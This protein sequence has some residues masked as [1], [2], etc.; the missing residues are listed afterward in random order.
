MP[1]FFRL[2]F[3]ST[4]WLLAGLL[5]FLIALQSWITYRNYQSE[6]KLLV[7]NVNESM[8]SS[9]EAFR[10]YDDNAE[11]MRSILTYSERATALQ[12]EAN[13]ITNLIANP[14]FELG[15][16]LFSS[17]Y[18]AYSYSPGARLA[19]NIG[20]YTIVDSAGTA[21][22][23][24]RG[25]GFG[26]G[27]KFLANDGAIASGRKVWSQK[28]KCKSNASYHL[29]FHVTSLSLAHDVDTANEYWDR[30][31]LKI[32]INDAVV[33]YVFAPA[34]MM[35]W[36]MFQRNWISGND[37]VADISIIDVNTGGRYNDFG[38]DHLV[39]GLANEISNNVAA[40]PILYNAPTS[41]PEGN[42]AEDLG[43]L[44][45]L[46]REEF[47][48]RSVNINFRVD[49]IPS[50]RFEEMEYDVQ[51]L[52]NR[53]S[54]KFYERHYVLNGDLFSTYY[55]LDSETL[56]KCC[57]LNYNAYLLEKIFGQLLLLGLS[58]FLSGL[59]LFF[60][61]RFLQKQEQVTRLKYDITS[62]ITHELKT[63]IATILAATESLQKFVAT[64]DKE[65]TERYL[66]ITRIQANRLNQLVEKALSYSEIEEDGFALSLRKIDINDLIKELAE[67]E[68]F[69]AK[70]HVSVQLNLSPSPVYIS[71]DAFH[72]N[73]ILQTI[74]DNSIKYAG[75][76]PEVQISVTEQSGDA[77]VTISDNGSGISARYHKLVFEKYFRVPTEDRYTV[78]GHGLG[79]YY[80]RTIM[81]LHGGSVKI[82]SDGKNG[83]EILLK[84]TV[85]K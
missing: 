28:V 26:G 48:F 59:A 29:E 61:R 55:H 77:F 73:N 11:T 80:V 62:S 22:L 1:I 15:D 68:S 65:K 46:L 16:T 43:A 7:R 53:E 5:L 21:V 18:A 69:Q 40:S 81:T 42:L 57:V 9:I 50:D 23:N 56:S 52:F 67:S 64:S 44:N 13:T 6:K 2:R 38:I 45:A 19:D 35:K 8:Q 54:S 79:L 27:G 17:E 49:V 78:K 33:G 74:I 12:S 10:S 24:W 84:F 72:I 25:T 71:V 60:V 82:N 34:K 58:L 51:A 37:S 75:G 85:A 3:N 76:F 41:S 66:E 39:F 36:E 20:R 47:A 14:D 83:T 31:L 32:V 70:T 4:I 63:P 30:A